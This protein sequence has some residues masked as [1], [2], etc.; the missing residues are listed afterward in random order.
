MSLRFESLVVVALTDGSLDVTGKF[1]SEKVHERNDI[2]GR[3]HLELM[4]L[5]TRK[6]VKIYY[7]DMRNFGTLKFCLSRKDLDDKL[8][9]LGP[10]ILE[11]ST[12]T[13]DVFLE[14]WSKKNTSLNIC[15]FLMNQEV[16]KWL[17]S[18]LQ[19]MAL[20]GAM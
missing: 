9:A 10:D 2:H 1:V 7:H 3:W 11:P 14:I 16:G 20:T 19:R 8:S 17:S 12:T 6:I 5:A 13:E 18:V 4:D 15:K